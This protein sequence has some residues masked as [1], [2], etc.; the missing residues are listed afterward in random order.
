VIGVLL[1]TN[2]WIDDLWIMRSQ[3]GHGLG[4][5][6]LSMGETEIA[7]RGLQ[8]ARLRVV[9]SNLRATSFYLDHGWQIEKELQ[10]EHLPV[11]MLQLEKTLAYDFWCAVRRHGFSAGANPARQGRSSR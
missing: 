6:L 3:R 7:R 10:H 4:A 1:T 5:E 8:I 2:D 11:T 9:K